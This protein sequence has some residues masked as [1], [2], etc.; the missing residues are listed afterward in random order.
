MNPEDPNTWLQSGNAWQVIGA[1]LVSLLG[2]GSIGALWLRRRISSDAAGI[3]NDKAEVDI[4]KTLQEDNL[5]LRAS[6]KEV[7][8]ER[9]KLWKELAEMS[10]SM[11]IMEFQLSSIQQEL[12]ALRAEK[13]TAQ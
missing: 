5:Q 2:G 11:K 3:A 10:A 4:I 1:S 6:L 9:D 12:S 13:G 7:N 8:A